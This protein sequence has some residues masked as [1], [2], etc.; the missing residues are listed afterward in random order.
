MN[1]SVNMVGARDKLEHSVGLEVVVRVVTVL[2]KGEAWL[3]RTGIGGLS[4]SDIV[5]GDPTQGED[6]EQH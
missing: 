6:W 5:H 2:A 4:R 1:N 3:T